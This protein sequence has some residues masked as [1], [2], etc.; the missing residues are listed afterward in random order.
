MP[1]AI[2]GTVGRRTPSRIA[3]TT[4]A[5]GTSAAV[6]ATAPRRARSA[7]DTATAEPTSA[8]S[9][10]ATSRLPLEPTG[11]WSVSTCF[12]DVTAPRASSTTVLGVGSTP[13]TVVDGAASGP[14][15]ST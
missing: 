3:A 14:P 8:S 1:V 2:G 10:I 11:G 4:P 13:A 7:T 5:T 9:S 12:H 15:T 6:A